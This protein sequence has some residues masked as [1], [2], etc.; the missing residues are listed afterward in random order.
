MNS[1]R[2]GVAAAFAAVVLLAGAACQ[3]QENG[4]QGKQQAG[5]AQQSRQSAQQQASSQGSSTAQRTVQG[6]LVRASQDEIVL[7]QGSG[8]PDLRLK[9][10]PDTKVTVGGGQQGSITALQEGTQVR[11]SYDESSGAPKAIKIE[12]MGTK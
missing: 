6:R 12:A 2:I 10:D 8:E 3:R 11:A 9:V 5:S 4:T 1:L 7:R